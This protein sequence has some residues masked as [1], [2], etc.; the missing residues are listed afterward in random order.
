LK[1]TRFFRYE[2]FRY[3]IP[4]IA[5]PAEGAKRLA[6]PAQ[7]SGSRVIEAQKYFSLLITG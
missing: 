2:I 1:N 6:Q 7:V 5:V 4:I 3:E